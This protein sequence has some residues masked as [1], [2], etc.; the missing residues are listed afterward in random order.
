MI[1]KVIGLEMS[2]EW[3][4]GCF[5]FLLPELLTQEKDYDIYY[6]YFF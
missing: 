2:K 4:F 3:G 6:K 5:L 1:L